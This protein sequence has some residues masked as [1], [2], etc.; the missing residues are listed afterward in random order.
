VSPG[1]PPTVTRRGLFRLLAA[2]AGFGITAAASR[3]AVLAQRPGWLTAAGPAPV[4]NSTFARAT[5]SQMQE[6]RELATRSG[7]PIVAAGG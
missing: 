5:A 3:R 7:M 1:R 6:L 2:G 4:V